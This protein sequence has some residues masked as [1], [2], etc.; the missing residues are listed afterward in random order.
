MASIK[1]V[2]ARM[3]FIYKNFIYL[4]NAI[5]TNTSPVLLLQNFGCVFSYAYTTALAISNI[6]C[7]AHKFYFATGASFFFSS[8]K[9]R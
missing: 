6:I 2:N 5:Y 1:S 3:L 7:H 9:Q 8:H 4:F